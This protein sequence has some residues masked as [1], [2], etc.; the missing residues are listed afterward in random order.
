VKHKRGCAVGIQVDAHDL[1]MVAAAVSRVAM[2]AAPP[3]V[4]IAALNIQMRATG[5]K[6]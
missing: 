1:D 3:E 6:P 2:L 4:R 5:E